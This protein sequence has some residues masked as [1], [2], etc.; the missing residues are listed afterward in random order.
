MARNS[1]RAMHVANSTIRTT[2]KYG[3]KA[4]VG[5][6]KWMVTDHTNAHARSGFLELEWNTNCSIATTKL[7]LRRS[8]VVGKSSWV[9]DHLHYLWDIFWGIV[10][11]IVNYL[12]MT[13]LISVASVALTFGA[14]WL[15]IW[16][17]FR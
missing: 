4:I 5:T 15:L 1:S 14:F 17:L 2:S 7:A 13:I 3:S 9:A 16:I 12:L 11:P 6:A 10:S 8:K